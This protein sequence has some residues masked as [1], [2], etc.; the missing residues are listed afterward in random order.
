MLINYIKSAFRNLRRH[1]LFFGLNIL[2]LV[3]GMSSSLLIFLWV[4]DELSYDRFN[5]KA[6]CIFRITTSGDNAEFA[7]SPFGFGPALPRELTEVETATRF[8]FASQKVLS[9]GDRRFIETAI[10]YTDSNF[11]Q[12]FNY[13]MLKGSSSGLSLKDG[14]VLTERSA[15]KYFGNEDPMG[16]MIRMDNQQSYFVTGVLKD[17]PHNSH[18][19]F[20]FLMGLPAEVSEWNN[21]IYFTF[22]R[23]DEKSAKDP[24]KL[25]RLEQKITAV[26]KKQQTGVKVDFLLQ[27]LMDIH[28]NSHIL[29]DVP[30]QGNIQY[31]RILSWVALFIL[32]IAC[33]NFVN[34]S[35]ALSGTRA[36]EVGLRKTIGA[37]RYQ[38]IVQ[39][40]GESFLLSFIAML[41]GLGLA[42]L[43]LPMFNELTGKQIGM[44][45]FSV[46]GILAVIGVATAVGVLA[47]IYPAVAMSAFQPVKVLKGLKVLHPGK[48]YFRNG[49]VM[50]QFTISIVLIVGTI[51]VYQQLRFINQRDIGY[52]K[53]NLL[54]IPIPQVGDMRKNARVIDQMLS[55]Y[56]GVINHTI[57]SDLPTDLTSG[58]VDVQWDGMDPGQQTEFSLLGSDDNFIATFGMHLIAGRY[59]SKAFPEDQHNFVVNETSLK[60][61][62]LT[63]A[64]AVGKRI[65]YSGQKGSIIGVLKDFNFKPVHRPVDPLLLIQGWSRG[66]L[67]EVVRTTPA[68]LETVLPLVQK[69]FNAVYG[70]YP[71]SY[72]FVDQ[73]L[74]RL[75]TTDQ[76]MGQLITVFSVISII[77]SCLGL[78]GLSAYTTQRRFKEI[79]VRKVLG[80][81]VSGIVKLLAKEFLGP[82]VLAAF[83]AFPLANWVMNNW[84]SAFAY[85]ISIQWWVFVFAWIGAFLI[86]LVT[87]GWQAAKA[88]VTNPVLSLRME[89]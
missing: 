29:M 22:L 86:A 25:H 82:V 59:F 71:F 53:E 2:G 79:G 87:V 28:L 8:M 69:S 33:I 62:G 56:P 89:G 17:P 40:L 18:L 19:Q 60:V 46:S 61:M 64:S 4:Q 88:A 75:Y 20:D 83:I 57:V 55:G 74:S 72:G 84:L 23:L 15:K 7:S 10:G 34:L 47:G 85:R 32:L 11:L 44:Q 36:K 68:T 45:F 37:L 49:L 5:K 78:F 39:F 63:P 6:D 52:Q 27:R 65:T 70:G 30:G 51:V 73:D 26:F 43:L 13:P 12:V 50:L 80:A 54:Y 9:Y 67:Y 31:V 14:I 41:L 77:V 81:S 1:K 35:T 48:S 42:G 66:Y 38:L 58:D 76:R 16:K 3:V 21:F 24:A